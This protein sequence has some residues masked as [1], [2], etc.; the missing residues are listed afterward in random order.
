M[1]VRFVSRGVGQPVPPVGLRYC[2]PAPDLR[3]YVSS[4]YLFHADLSHVSDMVRADLAQL[5][6]MIAGHGAYMFA[7]GEARISPE[8]T[9][10]GP[11]L[12]ATRFDIAGPVL[13]FGISLLPAGWTA[14]VREDAS[15]HTADVV[16]GVALFGA[17]VA[18]ALDA[19][20]GALST[21]M[22]VAIADRTMR[23]LAAEAD[24]PP[25][26]F[27]KLAD[28]WLLG[29]ASPKVDAFVAEL[30]LSARQVERLTRRSYGGPPK[31][32]ARKYR[33]LRAASLLGTDGVQWQDVASEGYYDQ[34]HFIRDFKQFTGLT[35]RQFQ[36]DPS[37]VTRLMLQRR[38]L[39]AHMP[40]L[41]LFS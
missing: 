20:R 14:L 17:L 27:T 21:D 25:L 31:L 41:Q 28:R 33:A 35:P 2:A 23:A 26:W 3:R 13:V 12:S 8:V 7:D 37:P 39:N 18:D 6:F 32:I 30:G 24:D 38:T 5:R 10:I 11:T 9:V 29:S 4:Y 36:S 40:K 34:S 19:M 15:R 1:G 22:M 16:D